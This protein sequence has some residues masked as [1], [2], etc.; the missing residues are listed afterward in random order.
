MAFAQPVLEKKLLEDTLR[1]NA[2]F[3]EPLSG[4]F[5]ELLITLNVPRIGSIEIPALIYEEIAYL[6]WTENILISIKSKHG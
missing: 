3:K 1:H 2:S 6:P 5:E 4:E